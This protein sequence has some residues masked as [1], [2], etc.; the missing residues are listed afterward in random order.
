MI[1][2]LL[3]ENNKQR[4]EFYIISYEKHFA[5]KGYF[6]N[7]LRSVYCSRNVSLGIRFQNPEWNLKIYETGKAM[8]FI[9]HLYCY[10]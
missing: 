4:K 1:K 7:G 6:E 8:A 5:M 2:T 3:V 9:I 10:L